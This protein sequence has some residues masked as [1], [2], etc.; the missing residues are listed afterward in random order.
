VF[1]YTKPPNFIQKR[2]VLFR[3]QAINNVGEGPFSDPT[4]TKTKN[5]YWSKARSWESGAVPIA[6][7]NVV[8]PFG[9]NFS[10]D[11]PESPIYNRIDVN[12]QLEYYDDAPSLNLRA[13]AIFIK[14]GNF[15]IGTSKKEPFLGNAKIT[16]YG[17]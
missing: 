5:R 15:W 3:V 12:G 16:L 11:L 2:K 1:T 6:G 7:Q 14:T 13:N 8:I 10:F 4:L 9:Q 17:V